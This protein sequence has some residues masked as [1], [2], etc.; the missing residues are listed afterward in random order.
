MDAPG[1]SHHGC[2]PFSFVPVGLQARTL[3]FRRSFRLLFCVPTLLT[4][5]EVLRLAPDS[6]SATSGQG[7]AH[8]RHWVTRG[9]DETALWGEC[10]G[11]GKKPYQT[12]VDL[13]E[14]AFKCSCPSRKFPCKHGLG[15]LLLYAADPAAVPRV[16][17]PAWV[18][19]WLAGRQA[20]AE[21]KA[22]VANEPKPVDVEAQADR[23]DR[24]LKR[25]RDGMAD[26]HVWVTDWVK[27]GVASAPTKGWAYFDAQARRLIDA[28]APGVG[29]RVQELGSIAARGAGWQRPFLERLAVLHLLCRATARMDDLPDDDRANL[30]AAFG[31]PVSQDELAKLPGVRDVWQVAG[32]AV[33]TEDRLKV[34]RTWLLGRLSG[35][36]AL[37]LHF[38][39][40]AA[41]MDTSLRPATEFD[42][43]VVFH[44]GTG[45]RAAVRTTPVNL[46]PVAGPVGFDTFGAA[47]DTYSRAIASNPWLDRLLFPVRDVVPV[48]D[49]GIWSIIDK[50]GESLRLSTSETIGW[51]MLAISGA[52]PVNLAGEFDGKVVIP[53]AI[54]SGGNYQ[55]L[56]DPEQQAA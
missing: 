7:L 23:R 18:S 25:I 12:Q 54:A 52:L 42:G 15:L 20:R 26:L 30:S 4:T 39:H 37:I 27:S 21:K 49:G 8:V 40:G 33:E 11:S 55:S 48:Y 50:T 53:L 5:A 43:E 9:C 31:I 17:R 22:A 1:R 10:Q 51:K 44:P 36:T 46:Q 29:R 3:T 35:R 34:Q 28:Q 47:L 19:E 38:A 41:P 6:S 32:Q 24:R 13:G 2:G 56:A 14:I 16:D 45:P